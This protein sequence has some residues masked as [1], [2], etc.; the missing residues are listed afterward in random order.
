ML[1]LA[2]DPI[3]RVEGETYLSKYSAFERRK[4][5]DILKDKE[6]LF[7]AVGQNFPQYT[8]GEKELPKNG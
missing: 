4:K 2:L 1:W 6:G 3:K 7:W 5:K 8:M